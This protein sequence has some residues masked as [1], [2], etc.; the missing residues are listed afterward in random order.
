[1]NGKVAS[2]LRR[3]QPLFILAFVVP[4]PESSRLHEHLNIDPKPAFLFIRQM[5]WESQ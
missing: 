3:K 1:M 5:G 4:S 2:G